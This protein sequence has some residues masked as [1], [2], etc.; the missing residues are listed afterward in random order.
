MTTSFVPGTHIEIVRSTQ[1]RGRVRSALFDF[2]GTLSLIRQGW[3]TVMIPMM[4]EILRK[5]TPTDE[6]DEELTDV[7]TE[8]VTRTTGK[9]TIYQMIQ[10]AEEVTARGGAALDPRDYKAE[11]L[12]RLWTHIRGRVADLKEGRR[13]IESFLVPGARQVLEGLRERSVVCYLASGTDHPY[14]VDEAQALGLA[15]FF[16]GGIYGAQEDYESSSKRLVIAHILRTHAL[17]GPEL[18]TFGDGFVEIEDTVAAGGIA[19]GMATDEERREGIDAWKRERL[20][21]A[22]AH[23]IVPDFGEHEA[24]LTYLCGA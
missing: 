5:S 6:S 23:V 16:A 18:A 7:V 20:I 10:L 13:P 3:Q 15:E 24:L 17:A 14:V 8:F 19:V 11:Y 4:V 2:D 21:A 12:A 1:D 9:Q 22:G